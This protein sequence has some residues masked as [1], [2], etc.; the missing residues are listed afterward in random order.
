MLGRPVAGAEPLSM[1]PEQSHLNELHP[2]DSTAKERVL[3]A[4]SLCC[5]R[6]AV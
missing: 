2:A 5:T 4:K 6:K 3:R 1:L